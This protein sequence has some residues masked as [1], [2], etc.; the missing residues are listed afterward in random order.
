[1]KAA[2][3]LV[4]PDHFPHGVMCARCGRTIEFGQPYSEVPDE[5]DGEDLWV[6]LV[7]VYC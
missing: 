5:C 6:S 2:Y 4:T 7:C 3:P 1:M